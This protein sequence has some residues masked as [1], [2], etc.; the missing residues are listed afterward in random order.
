MD[1]SEPVYLL[2]LADTHASTLS[3]L[4][5]GLTDLIRETGW[6][7]HCGDFTGV[8][9]LEE[10]RRLAKHFVGVYGNTDPPEIRQQLPAEATFEV[11]GKRIAVFHPYWGG[12]P[13]GIEREMV[14]RYPHADAILFGHTHDPLVEM[15]D[16]ILLLNPGQS[17]PTFIAQTQVGILKV[18]PEM[19][20]GRVFPLDD[21]ELF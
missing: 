1:N 5:R 13:Q 4:P 21:A 14:E 6:V 12:P 8:R 18:T 7:V 2:V 16:G 3:E 10:L 11:Y 17:Y 20:T 9:V 19:V 15:R